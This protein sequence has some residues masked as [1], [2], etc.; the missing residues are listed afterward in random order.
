MEWRSEPRMD[1]YKSAATTSTYAI[2]LITS[3]V[4][5]LKSKHINVNYH[6]ADDEQLRG[7]VEFQYV[8]SESNP[9]DGLLMLNKPCLL[10]T[11]SCSRSQDWLRS[12]STCEAWI[13]Q[14]ILA[15]KRGCLRA[16]KG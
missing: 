11:S 8:T 10:D 3:G 13:G 2:K 1:Q 4:V 12:I 6:H 15:E 7:S 5:R 16:K 14:A 9:A